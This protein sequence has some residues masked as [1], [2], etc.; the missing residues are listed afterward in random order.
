MLRVLYLTAEKPV[1]L[2]RD[3]NLTQKKATRGVSQHDVLETVDLRRNPRICLNETGRVSQF[4]AEVA[5]MTKD[6]T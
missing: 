6:N 5:D 1:D 4:P 2:G 3:S